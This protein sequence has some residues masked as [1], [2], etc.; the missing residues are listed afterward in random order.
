M[1]VKVIAT[2][3]DVSERELRE[4]IIVVIDLLRASTTIVQ[5]IEN[6]AQS[7]IPVE[8]L[9][10]AASIKRN[11][12]DDTLL[13]CER[14]SVKVEGC[15]LGNS[16]PEFTSFRV[17]RKVIALSTTNGSRAIQRVKGNSVVMVGS[18]RNRKRICTFLL[19][20]KFDVALLCAGTNGEVSADDLYCAGAILSGLREMMEDRNLE[21]DDLGFLAENFYHNAKANPSLLEGIKHYRRLQQLGLQKDIDFCFAEDKSEALPVLVDGI[22]L[23]DVTRMPDKG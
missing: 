15:D 4:R 6:G 11:R 20:Q 8:T 3:A 9:D 22:Y 19:E 7:V 16:P 14:D 17:R 2:Y 1:N 13:A 5:A 12:G 10:A 21:I 18:L 23:V